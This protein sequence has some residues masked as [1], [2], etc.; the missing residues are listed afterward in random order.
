MSA[1]CHDE[2]VHVGGDDDVLGL[3]AGAEEGEEAHQ[4]GGEDTP[5]GWLAGSLV[6]GDR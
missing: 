2:G 5:Q 3:E 1:T 6:T 4:L